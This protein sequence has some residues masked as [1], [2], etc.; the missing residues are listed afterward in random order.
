M[1]RMSISP[2]LGAVY[3]MQRNATKSTKDMRLQLSTEAAWKKEKTS[4]AVLRGKVQTRQKESN[5]GRPHMALYVQLT[6]AKLKWN[7]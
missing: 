6:H 7:N 4:A 1:V 2:F 3:W 5:Y